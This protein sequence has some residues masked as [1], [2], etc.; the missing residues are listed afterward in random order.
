LFIGIIVLGY[1]IPR[2]DFLHL[3]LLFTFAFVCML[4]L[5]KFFPDKASWKWIFFA[6][7]ILRL[8]LLN[9]TPNLSEDYVRFLWDGEMLRQG[10]NP[11]LKTPA[12]F[13]AQAPDSDNGYL[14]QLYADLNSPDYYSVYPPLNQ[15]LFYLSSVAS[16][17]EVKNGFVGL[18]VILILGE[19]AV[20]F[21]AIRLLSIFQ[22]PKKRVVFYWLNPLVILEITANLH[23]EGLVLLSLLLS[24]YFLATGSLSKSGFF[25]GI[26]IGL[27]L[28][29][30]MLFPAFLALGKARRSLRFWIG[31]FL[32]FILSFGWLLIDHSW[33]NFFQSLSL[34]QGKFEFNASI[35]YLLREVGFWIE[36]YNTI[37]ILT[38]ILSGITVI[39][40]LYFSWKKRI[41]SS[42]ELM[43]LTVLIYL[44][45]LILQPV[46]HP[47]YILP[48]LGISIFTHRKTFLIWTF[49]AILSYQAYGNENSSESPL[50]LCVEHG[51]VVAGIYL[52]YFH[53]KRNS[54]LAL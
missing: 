46:V 23:F 36:G 32:A 24:F 48:A 42:A 47:W 14:S 39:S 43:D 2:A 10:T 7:L 1:F 21:I 38:K 19:I 3:F 4:F 54:N 6:G 15:A 20:F 50:I 40:I 52:D 35:Y 9:A 41:E 29:P 8:S 53:R 18:R 49:T 22:I 28:L 12:E 44:I 45:Y 33:I 31:A 51:L 37:A 26:S 30:L 11:Y 25:W 13:E 34:Y 17:G 5:G 27:K 16:H